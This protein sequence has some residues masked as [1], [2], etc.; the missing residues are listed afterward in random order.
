MNTSQSFLSVEFMPLNGSIIKKKKKSRINNGR[1]TNDLV[2]SAYVDTND[3]V[4]PLILQIYTPEK[5]RIAD[6][7]YGKGVFWKHGTLKKYDLFFSDLK[8][9]GLPKDVRGGVDSRDLPY[10]NNYFDAVVFDPPYMH[11]PGGT[12]HNGHQNFETYYANNKEDHAIQLKQNSH[13][14]Y[15]EAVLD[16]YF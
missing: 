8:Q 14:K 11:T 9:T 10:E 12:A 6:I 16:L 7:T 4:F 15:H 2:H 3:S 1:A 5:S 13:P